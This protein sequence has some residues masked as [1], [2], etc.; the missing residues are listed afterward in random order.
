M[1]RNF[2]KKD[3]IEQDYYILNIKIHSDEGNKQELYSNMIIQIF[4]FTDFYVKIGNK[5]GLDLKKCNKT[6]IN[7]SILGSEFTRLDYNQFEIFECQFVKYKI[8]DENDKHYDT[9]RKL[10]KSANPNAP[11]KPNAH[12]I[13]FYFIPAIHRLLLPI[14]SKVTPNQVELFFNQALLKIYEKSSFF[15]IDIAKSIE[16]VEKIFTFKSLDKLQLEISYTNDDLGDDEKLFM[17]ALLKESNV[18]KYKAEFDSEKKE[19]LNLE[20]KLIKGGI[21]LSKE[22]GT[23]KAIGTNDFGNKTV[24][25]T[26]NEFEE[27]KI[28][29]IK[30]IN[31]LISILKDSLR[32]WRL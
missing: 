29:I 25:N 9:V 27:F 22:N 10:V 4:N 21:E 3:Y 28:K 7:K 5:L 16:E 23:L 11:I 6:P 17:D 8:E 30:E 2:T 14:N 1:N 20:S 32:K 15:N 19:S 26:K 18:N 24:V 13:D 12:E 31:P